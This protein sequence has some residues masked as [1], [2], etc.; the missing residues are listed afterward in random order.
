MGRSP[1][2]QDKAVL[3]AYV[4][5]LRLKGILG[6]L[7]KLG[8]EGRW[9]NHRY[10]VSCANHPVCRLTY[11]RKPGTEWTVDLYWPSRDTYGKDPTGLVFPAWGDVHAA[12]RAIKTAI[13]VHEIPI[14]ETSR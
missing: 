8:A 1:P 3:E 7:F 4:A 13:A 10:Y 6:F 14:V 2:A 5:S 11:T 9:D 12:T